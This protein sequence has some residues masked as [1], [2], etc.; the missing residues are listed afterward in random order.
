MSNEKLSVDT[1]VNGAEALDLLNKVDYDLLLSDIEMPKMN[2]LELIKEVRSIDRLKS[3]PAISLTSLNT[4]SDRKLCLEAGF[5]NYLAK[6]NR[7]E[8]HKSINKIFNS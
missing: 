8:F 3:L 6:L 2:G 7:E 1:A 4:E 5:D